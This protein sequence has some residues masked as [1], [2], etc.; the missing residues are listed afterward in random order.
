LTVVRGAIS[1]SDVAYIEPIVAQRGK[2]TPMMRSEILRRMQPSADSRRRV[3]DLLHGYRTTCLVVAA[4]ELGLVEALR[5]APLGEADLAE[6][7]GAHEASLRRFLRA[8][9][10]LGLVENHAQG[11]ALTA[12]GR[13]LLEGD[14]AMR[15]RGIL[16]RDEYLPAWLNLSHTVRTGE[17]AFGHVFGM[18]AWEHRR[19][20]PAL[21]ECMNRT[22]ADDQRSA[23]GSISEAYD[24]SRHRTIVDV[25]GGHGALLADILARFPQPGG[26]L[27]DQPHVVSGAP[28]LLADACVLQ[29]CEIV[30]GSF[31]ER[32]P[33]GGDAYLLQRVL[34]D[35]SDEQC[36]AILRKCRAAMGGASEL[37]VIEKVVPEGL[38]P[39][40]LV[41]LDMHMMAMLGGRERT[42]AEYEALLASSGFEFVRSLHTRAG[43]EILV[44]TP[45]RSGA[46]VR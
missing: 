14:S 11:V 45:S 40:D 26:V 24:F 32:V 17:T 5:A 27:F 10:S 25:G 34:H 31:F 12:A 7:L 21:N 18:S 38:A 15:E 37:L 44:A 43:T 29:R 28:R 2:L 9:S 19:R 41:M 46:P 4:I 1:P 35:W 33:A 13:L 23:Q 22:M 39:A 6:R 16:V 8:L 36:E 20:H 3:H 42:R 30:G